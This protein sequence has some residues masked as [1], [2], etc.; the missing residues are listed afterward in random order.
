M[1]GVTGRT[2]YKR[3]NEDCRD[4]EIISEKSHMLKHWMI[5]HPVEKEVPDIKFRIACIFKYCLS[6]QY[7]RP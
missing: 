1:T 4:A 6:C 5:D 7:L 2:L 3:V